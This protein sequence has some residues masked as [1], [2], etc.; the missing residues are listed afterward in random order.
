MILAGSE[1]SYHSSSEAAKKDVEEFQ[2][3]L[4]LLLPP[5]LKFYHLEFRAPEII[6][7]TGTGDFPLRAVSGG[8]AALFNLAWTV[9]LASG[10]LG[11]Y[12]HFSDAMENFATGECVVLIDEPENHLHP[13]MQRTV[14]P[15]LLQAFPKAQFV[16][17]THSPH[18]ITSVKD[19]AVYTLRFN[20]MGKVTCEQL[21]FHDKPVAANQV[22]QEVLGLSSTL[23]VWA[24]NV[25]MQ[26]IKKYQR[27][28]I[29]AEMLQS[30][31]RDLEAAGLGDFAPEAITE[32][33]QEDS[34][35]EAD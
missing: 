25:L 21:D 15:A 28:E 1:S 14:L 2:A 8:I 7:I 3:A 34:G 16:V 5:E 31:R 26:T 9:F 22:L 33:F 11:Y 17:A 30:L 35:A 20:E 12:D 4:R 6:L 19:S 24:E 27:L 23:P 13:K 29:T 32:V 10:P 18:V